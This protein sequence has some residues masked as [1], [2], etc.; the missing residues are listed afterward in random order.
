MRGAVAEGPLE[1]VED[2]A[3]GGERQALVDD[4]A[5]AAYR[6]S[7]SRRAV[8]PA[9]TAAAAC[10]EKPESAAQSDP[11]W[12]SRSGCDPW[13]MR[14][15]GTPASGPNAMRILHGGSTEEVVCGRIE[16]GSRDGVIGAEL[17]RAAQEPQHAGT[18][19]VD[20]TF[21]VGVG[22]RGDRVEVGVAAERA[23]E[24]AVDPQ[25]VVV[26]VKPERL[27]EALLE[28]HGSGLG[29]SDPAAACILGVE[30]RDATK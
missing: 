8:A 4:C 9:G 28:D 6:Q 29:T 22:E 1:P 11:R 25:A 18:H 24:G 10:R 2:L 16:F 21:D 15:R 27:V 5:G 7:F 13:P 17:A 26:Q 20:E 3:V 30:A 19:G 14:R 12:H 23:G